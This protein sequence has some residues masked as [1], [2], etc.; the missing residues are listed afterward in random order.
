MSISVG[1][2]QAASFIKHQLEH[3]LN[4][5]TCFRHHTS[6]EDGQENQRQ[7]D[8]LLD[9]IEVSQEDGYVDYRE[10]LMYLRDGALDLAIS[11]AAEK[12]VN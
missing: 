3:L 10:L 7:L 5:V 2:I 6:I 4:S 8:D 11:Q 9:Q 1:K 12:T